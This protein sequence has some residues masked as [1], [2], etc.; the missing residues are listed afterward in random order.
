MSDKKYTGKKGLIPPFYL[1]KL[2]QQQNIQLYIYLLHNISRLVCA[3][4][5]VLAISN[6]IFDLFFLKHLILLNVTIRE[7]SGVNTR[8]YYIFI[9]S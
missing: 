6:R 1:I 2:L 9:K 4:G 7:C 8:K 5:N 3:Q